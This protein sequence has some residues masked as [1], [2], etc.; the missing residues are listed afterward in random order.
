MIFNIF[1]DSG[2]RVRGTIIPDN[3]SVVCNVRV[4]GGGRELAVFPTNELNQGVLDLRLHDTGLVDFTITE[5][6]LPGLP[7]FDDLEIHDAETD[8]LFY[9]RLRSS[10]LSGKFFRLETHL[11]PL[12]R[13]D[14]AVKGRFQ[15]HYSGI[16][17]RGLN[18]SRQIFVLSQDS[19]Y[20]SGRI[21]I[22]NYTFSAEKGFKFIVTLHDPYVELAERI[23]VLNNVKTVG[24][25]FLGQ[26]DAIHF[27]KAIAYAASLPMTSERTLKRA[28][29]QMPTDIIVLLANPL[30]RQLSTSN[31]DEPLGKGSVAQA[32][33]FL[34]QSTVLGLRDAPTPFARSLGEL[35]NLDPSALPVAPPLPAVTVLG[36]VF[37]RWGFLDAILEKD[38]ELYH[39]VHEA[40]QKAYGAS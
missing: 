6:S 15:M 36:G 9:R 20:A 34:S 37:R 28:L 38:L 13:L 31:L 27:A 12:R 5:Q 23:L 3:P 2:D 22:K 40:H 26:R 32:L 19:I 17:T 24:T 35:F 16:E 4:L 29:E 1:H 8:V 7:A 14:D 10:M 33:D 18:F 25:G 39:Y 30:V 11:L 21:L